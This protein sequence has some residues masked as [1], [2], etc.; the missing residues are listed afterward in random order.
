[1]RNLH[2]V[3]HSGCT[4][5]HSHQQSEKFP[6]PPR[7]HQ[8]LLFLVF[9]ICVSLRISDDEHLFV[10]LLAIWMSSL[11]KCL[12]MSCAQFLIGL[13]VFQILSCISS[14][15]FLDTNHLSDMSFANIFFVR[16]LPFSF[17]GC[18]LC[19]AETFYFDESQ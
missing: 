13:F 18:F 16:R 19:C 6:F 12:F 4:G 9:L 2:T 5:L 8:H 14:L 15:Y 17:V 11:E 10:C 7:P 3:F 1:M